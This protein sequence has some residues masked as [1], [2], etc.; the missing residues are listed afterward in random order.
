MTALDIP[1]MEY[2][3][4]AMEWDGINRTYDSV[5]D[6]IKKSHTV[7]TIRKFYGKMTAVRVTFTGPVKRL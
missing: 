4:T 1:K 6:S 7:K 2:G 3:Q 5:E